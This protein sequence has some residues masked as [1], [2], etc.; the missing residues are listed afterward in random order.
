MG[1]QNWILSFVDWMALP[2]LALL[3]GVLLYRKY[4]REFPLFFVYVV[5]TDVIGV[6]RL[7][8][9]EGTKRLYYNVY[10]ISD[11]GLAVFAF[12]ATYELFLKRLFPAFYS[13]R[14]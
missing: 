1:G 4:H 14:F 2:L 9:S 7:L 12:L 10:W 13:V 3:A 5:A 8:A 6:A 11:I